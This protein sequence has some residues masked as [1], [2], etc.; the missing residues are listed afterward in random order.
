MFF[1]HSH[2]SPDGYTVI[3]GP[4]GIT[5]VDTKQCCHCGEH[6]NYVKGS[7]AVRGRC[8]G[9]KQGKNLTCGK[10]ECNEHFPIEE[11]MD[12][13][14]KGLLPYLTA[15]RELIGTKKIILRI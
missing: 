7:G 4:E 15:P 6:F 9:C 2:R 3:T 12:L 8:L 14:E 1:N 10:P 13:Y 11:R 5:E